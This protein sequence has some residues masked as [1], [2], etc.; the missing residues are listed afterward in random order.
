MVVW[1]SRWGRREGFSMIL[2]GLA[3]QPKSKTT[4]KV[5]DHT[6]HG[7]NIRL[8]EEILHQW[9]RSLSHYFKDFIDLRW[10][11]NSSINSIPPNGTRKI[12]DSNVIFD[13]I[14][15]WS[16]PGGYQYTIVAEWLN[17]INKKAFS[18]MWQTFRLWE[19]PTKENLR[20]NVWIQ[21]GW[22]LPGSL[23][24][25]LPLKK[26]TGPQKDRLPTTIFSLCWTF[27]VFVSTWDP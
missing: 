2:S 9:I 17:N 5:N 1:S 14:Y 27:G 20:Q 10:C 23:T 13:G 15:M 6:L 3:D 22:I 4:G 25:S 8:M 21:P 19:S 7:T 11:R 26:I 12:I 24:A 18:R 16:F